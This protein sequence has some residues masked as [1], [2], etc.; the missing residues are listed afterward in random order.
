VQRAFEAMSHALVQLR[1]EAAIVESELAIKAAE[2]RK[3]EA[4][5]KLF[6]LRNR[7]IVPDALRGVTAPAP[8]RAS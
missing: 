6:L 2:Q 1:L 5:M 4:V 8:R 7:M 3:A